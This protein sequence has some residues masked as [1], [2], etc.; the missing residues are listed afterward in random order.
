MYN[1]YFFDNAESK[2]GIFP[3]IQ[4]SFQIVTPK[5]LPK[6]NPTHGKDL[7]I[8]STENKSRA[9]RQKNHFYNFFRQIKEESLSGAQYVNEISGD[10]LQQNLC[11]NFWTLPKFLVPSSS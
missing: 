6:K 5:P 8:L 4:R 3:G 2:F 9:Y 11:V 1:V 7:L 10:N